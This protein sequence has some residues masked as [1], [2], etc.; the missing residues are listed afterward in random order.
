M[1]EIGEETGYWQIVTLTDLSDLEAIDAVLGE[2]PLST[3]V[4]RADDGRWRVEAIAPR[5]V[6]LTRGDRRLVLE[7]PKATP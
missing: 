5:T 2:L 4:F 6:T 7:V 1:S 3:S